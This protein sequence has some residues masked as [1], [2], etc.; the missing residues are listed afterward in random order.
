MNEFRTAYVYIRN[1]FA[2]LL[3]E[4]DMG[5]VFSYDSNYLLLKEA[6]PVSLTLPLQDKPYVSESIFPFFDGLIPEGWLLH[7]TSKKWNISESDR[8][9][10]LLV[11]CKDCIGNVSVL[12]KKI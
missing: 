9:G 2:G 4:T 7:V 8:F 11:S 1:S 12:E 6:T 5:Y 10:L 3:Q